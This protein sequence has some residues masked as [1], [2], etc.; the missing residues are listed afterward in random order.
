MLSEHRRSAGESGQFLA[1]PA[2]AAEMADAE[3]E[4]S[5]ARARAA[6]ISTS[7]AAHGLAS[8]GHA[9]REAAANYRAMVVLAS[10]AIWLDSR[11]D[12]PTPVIRH[13]DNPLVR[14]G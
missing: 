7:S 12:R 1:A 14:Y 5:A 3:S 10:I 4:G 2:G 6:L 13:V 9:L 8:A 11:F